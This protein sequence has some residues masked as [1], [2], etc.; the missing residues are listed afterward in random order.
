MNKLKRLCHFNNCGLALLHLLG[1]IGLLYVLL[2]NV[3]FMG[4]TSAEP[5]FEAPY[6]NLLIF[7]LLVVNIMGFVTSVRRRV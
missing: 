6:E 5:T 7:T 1:V 2:S 3:G 4:L